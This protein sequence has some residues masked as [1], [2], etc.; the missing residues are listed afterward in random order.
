MSVEVSTA[1]LLRMWRKSDDGEFWVQFRTTSTDEAAL[2]RALDTLDVDEDEGVVSRLTCRSPKGP[3]VLLDSVDSADDLIRWAEHLAELL[4]QAGETGSVH[5]VVAAPDPRWMRS[6]P[7]EPAAFITMSY[8]AANLS[9]D[10]T[11][12]RPLWKPDGAATDTI[13]ATIEQFVTPG[14]PKIVLRQ[15]L[16]QFA[17]SDHRDITDVLSTAI[18]SDD[19]QAGVICSND[20]T[21]SARTAGVRVT[22]QVVL[23]IV[24]GSDTWD[25]R[26]TDLTQAM[27]AHPDLIDHAFIRTTYRFAEDWSKVGLWEPLPGGTVTD[28][29]YAQHLTVSHVLD[30]NGVQ[31]LTD[32]HLEHIHNLDRWNVTDLG[33]SRHLVTAP[34]LA[35]WYAEPHPDPAT[36]KQARHDFADILLTPA[37]RKQH[38]PP[39]ANT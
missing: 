22:G 24:G 38:P 29:R 16:F 15:G 37:A 11:G 27:T 35:P 13:A 7:P 32:T 4:Q 33:H 18:R 6:T 19:V 21:K 26:I 14:G 25:Q 34:D 9:Q 31:V 36:L 1:S 20:P 5:G 10:P 2:E 12:V 8:G 23:Q 30:V 17:L 28:F 39:W 3:L